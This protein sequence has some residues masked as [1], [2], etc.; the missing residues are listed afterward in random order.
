[1][2]YRAFQFEP[3][4]TSYWLEILRTLSNPHTSAQAVDPDVRGEQPWWLGRR[5]RWG[6]LDI[7]DRGRRMARDESV[8]DLAC[9]CRARIDGFYERA[10]EAAGKPGARRFAERVQDWHDLVLAA[11][12]YP[13]SAEVFLVRDFRD[14]LA[15]RLAFNRKTDNVRFGR[16]EAATDEEY[17]NGPMRDH[18]A[19][20]LESWRACRTVRCWFATRTSCVSRKRRLRRCSPTW[21]STTTRRRLRKCCAEPRSCRRRERNGT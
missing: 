12:L 6:P 8:E 21:E 11:E 1:M 14:M 18:V 7:P 17:V 5:R 19:T 15:S 4:I 2:T 13:R 3:R 16:E 9:F 10:A 20:L